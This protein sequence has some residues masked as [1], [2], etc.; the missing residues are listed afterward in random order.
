MSHFAITGLTLASVKN[1]GAK[2]DGVTNDTAAIQA[3]IDDAIAAGLGG[4]FFPPGTYQISAQGPVV[5]A[6]SSFHILG[7]GAAS[8]LRFVD[9]AHG[10]DAWL[11]RI[12]GASTFVDI[13]GLRLDGNRSG[14]TSGWGDALIHLGNC[15]DIEIHNCVLDNGY[16]M[17]I[18][19]GKGSTTKR[20]RIHHNALGSFNATAASAFGVISVGGASDIVVENNAFDND[21]GANFFYI[22]TNATNARIAFRDNRCSGSALGDWSGVLVQSV[23][24]CEIRGN[25]ITGSSGDSNAVIEVKTGNDGV[26]DLSIEGNHLSGNVDR[27]IMM[28]PVAGSIGR[29]SIQ[30]NELAGEIR[31]LPEVGGY[32][33]LP[34]V[35]GNWGSAFDGVRITDYASLHEPAIIIGGSYSKGSATPRGATQFAGV[36]SPETQVSGYVGDTFVNLQGG[37]GTTLWVK[38]SGAGTQAGWVGK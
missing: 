9:G 33:A 8:K 14:V 12:D 6:A 22:G 29:V 5:S 28:E 7:A 24:S 30:G 25:T 1:Y 11:L 15:S 27:S 19:I 35:A 3:A 21:L 37:A 18:R 4:V 13:D 2:G 36:A 23:A 31:F 38:E 10:A 20:I 16:S 17:A 26:S 32:T 34:V